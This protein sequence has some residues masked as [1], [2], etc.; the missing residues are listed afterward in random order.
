ME[1][2][3]EMENGYE[4]DYPYP[5]AD[6]PT[7]YPT[8][9][10]A[11]GTNGTSSRQSTAP[12]GHHQTFAALPTRSAVP[13]FTTLADYFNIGN[14][15]NDRLR[16]P[17]E[18]GQGDQ[19]DDEEGANESSFVRHED[20]IEGAEEIGDG[21]ES[22]SSHTPWTT[23]LFQ[24]YGSGSPEPDAGPLPGFHALPETDMYYTDTPATQSSRYPGSVQ[25]SRFESY[26][27]SLQLL[28]GE[29]VGGC[30]EV[31]NVEVGNVGAV[32]GRRQ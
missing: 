20:T 17:D 22:S 21:S 3:V 13:A 19:S 7:P 27:L 24:R 30:H 32:A 26:I 18:V 9:S 31:R 6:S 14:I 4:S 10:Q 12:N 5:Y 8:L 23:P 29:D 1:E 2:D 25:S 28:A 11:P 15:G 16:L